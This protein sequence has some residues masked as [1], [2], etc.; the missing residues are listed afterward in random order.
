MVSK[1]GSAISSFFSLAESTGKEGDPNTFLNQIVGTLD[2]VQ[3]MVKNFISTFINEAGQSIVTEFAAG[4][5]SQ[6]SALFYAV[7]RI[8]SILKGIG[9]TATVT[10]TFATSGG[11]ADSGS[12]AGAPSGDLS[13]FGVPTGLPPTLASMLGY[14]SE[15]DIADY[16]R[17][18][19]SSGLLTVNVNMP[20]PIT[21]E[22]W[23]DLYDKMIGEA[24]KSAGTR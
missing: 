13:G 19:A 1:I 6:E 5:K 9:G 2:V 18:L 12:W 8:N 4:M 10:F 24:A 7:D 21:D 22:Q 11:S 15:H 3:V 17:G 14:T 16:A 20:T 23:V